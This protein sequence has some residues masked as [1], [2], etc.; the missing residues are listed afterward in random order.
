MKLS[1]QKFKNILKK[2]YKRKTNIQFKIYF[3]C[4]FISIF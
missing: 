2:K 3:E 1:G 4:M